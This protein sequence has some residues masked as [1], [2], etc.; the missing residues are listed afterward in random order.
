MDI[1]LPK[2]R[3][4][5]GWSLKSDVP[6]DYIDPSCPYSAEAQRFFGW[7]RPPESAK[8]GKEGQ[9]AGK[10]G[11]ETGQADREASKGAFRIPF[12]GKDEPS[13]AE[14]QGA[15]SGGFRFPWDKPSDQGQQQERE[16]AAR[17]L[18]RQRS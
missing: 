5:G 14:G 2:I 10:E 11:Q 9:A 17:Q 16:E 15:D 4:F 18:S 12:F 3:R 7:I 1:S 6:L 13:K 8:A